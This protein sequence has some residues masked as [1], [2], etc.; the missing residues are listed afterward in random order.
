MARFCSG[1][2]LGLLLRSVPPV[3]VLRGDSFGVQPQDLRGG[4]LG[5]LLR[6]VPPVFVLR[7]DS[8][9]VQP[10]DLGG[11]WWVPSRLVG[12]LRHT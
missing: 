9:G 10:Q 2:V 8:F 1:G 4:V 5:Q 11:R 7:G 6:S 12:R 3:L